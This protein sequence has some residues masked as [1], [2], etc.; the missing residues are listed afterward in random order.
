MDMVACSEAS[1]DMALE[2]YLP[3]GRAGNWVCEYL[4]TCIATLAK[5]GHMNGDRAHVLVSHSLVQISSIKLVA[6]G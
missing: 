4:L 3:A 2:S 5:N 1:Y 6:S